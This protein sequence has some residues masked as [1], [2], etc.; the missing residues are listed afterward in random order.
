MLPSDANP[1]VQ[2][3]ARS[4][5]DTAPFLMPYHIEAADR[6]SR[7]F[8]RAQL[9]PHVTMHYG[10]RVSSSRSAPVAGELA[11]TAADARKRLSRLL[12]RLPAECAGVVFD[13][14]AFEKGLQDIERDRGW[15]R[16]SAKLVLRIGLD[17][18][19]RELG[20]SPQATG[21]EGAGTRVWTA[22]GARPTEFG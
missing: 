1:T 22:D 14:C 5:G 6:V 11:D 2:G 17:A 7:L 19:A 18:A 16:R 3:L 15:P 13:V 20:L 8:E 9:R 12:D 21:R 4:K 10:P